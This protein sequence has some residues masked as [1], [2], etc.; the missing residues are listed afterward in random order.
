MLNITES[1]ISAR[2]QPTQTKMLLAFQNHKV[3]LKYEKLT[4]VS[5]IQPVARN[6][7]VV[8]LVS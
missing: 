4:K 7:Y 2:R 5:K 6:I 8:H 1:D 3:G